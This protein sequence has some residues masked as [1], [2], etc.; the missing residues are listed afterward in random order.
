MTLNKN[1]EMLSHIEALLI[2]LVSLNPSFSS[3]GTPILTY[4]NNRIDGLCEL[5]PMIFTHKISLSV[6]ALLRAK[7]QEYNPDISD[8]QL[9]HRYWWEAMSGEYFETNRQPRIDFLNKILNDLL[10]NNV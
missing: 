6:I 4:Q 10:S 5:V 3:F 2:T 9:T 8:Y 7:I 1:K